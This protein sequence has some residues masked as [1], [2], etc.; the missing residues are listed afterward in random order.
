MCI[1][2]AAA[3]C[4]ACSAGLSTCTATGTSTGRLCMR[5]W[6]GPRSLQQQRP[7]TALCMRAPSGARAQAGSALHQALGAAMAAMGQLM[8]P[9]LQ[10]LL[11]QG[12]QVAGWQQAAAGVGPGMAL[13]RAGH[14]R[15]RKAAGQGGRWGQQPVCAALERQGP[16]QQARVRGLGQGQGPRLGGAQAAGRACVGPKL[17]GVVGRQVVLWAAVHGKKVKVRPHLFGM[18]LAGGL[19]PQLP[20]PG[21]KGKGKGR[22]RAGAGIKE[23]EGL[24]SRGAKAGHPAAHPPALPC[25]RTLSSRVRR[26]SGADGSGAGLRAGRGRGHRSGLPHQAHPSNRLRA[27]S[28]SA[29]PWPTPTP[30]PTTPSY[31]SSSL[32]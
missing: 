24:V 2:Q 11:E 5:V 21:G 32:T 28:L 13:Q 9:Q 8:P 30:T 23:R 26:G 7:P 4:T 19:K 6:L 1:M 3:P 22:G 15:A 20:F 12:L 14:Q 25:P 18:L 17:H 29:C 16:G 31:S 27:T 10:Q